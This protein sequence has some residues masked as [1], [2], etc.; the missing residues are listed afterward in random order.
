[1]SRR[2][3]PE[4]EGYA[5]RSRE[6]CFICAIA[7]GE[8][9]QHHVVYEDDGAIAFLNRFPTLEGSTIVAPREHREQVTG[10]FSVDEYVVL[11]RV[12]YGVAEGVRATL[13]P[14]RVYI[15]SLGSQAANAHVHWHVAPLPPGV[16][17]EE[18]QFEA[19][20]WEKGILDMSDADMAALADRLKPEIA[21]R[22]APR[23]SP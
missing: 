11:Q 16:P 23:P 2:P 7:S 17:F 15:L 14:E 8:D 3:P 5:E 4:L 22:L 9:T 18:Q 10:N 6:R 13:E 1:M 20:S 19:L 21:A 12:V